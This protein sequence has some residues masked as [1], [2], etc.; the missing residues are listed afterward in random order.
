MS[1]SLPG[2]TIDTKTP[3]ETQ[4]QKELE[5]KVNA[6]A[7][8]IAESGQTFKY[9]FKVWKKRHHGDAQ[10]GH[11]LLFSLGCQS[12][13]NSRGIHVA[14]TG[15]GGYGKSDGIKKMGKLVF[16]EFWKNGGFTP[17]TLYYS[18]RDMPDGVIVGLEDVVW[19]SDL[20]ATI[21]R[22]TTDFQEGALRVST[23]EMKGVEL[24]TA[25]RIAF[26]ASC[27][28]SQADEQIR[29]RFI[30][31]NVK[32]NSERSKEIIGHMQKLDEGEQKPE[33][34]E[35]ETLVCQALT[36]DLK[37]KLFNVKIPFAKRIKLDGDPRA[38]GMF[39]DMIRSS[40][41][42]RYQK[43][44]RD[45]AGRLIAT[46]EDFKNAKSLYVGIGGHDR[47]KYTDA[48]LKLLKAI[49]SNGGEATQA[50]LQRICER[51]AG[52]IS[53]VLNG[54]GKQG[55][56]LL[57]KCKELIVEDG[58]RPIKYRLLP[59]FNPTCKVSIEL[60]EPT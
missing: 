56:G 58:K 35:F 50:D 13:S 46:I 7:R 12:V 20:G 14:A 40:A 36:Y 19:N 52:Y 4:A 16:P 34:D 41:A 60:G 6:K 23:I 5:T 51:S 44:E 9:I 54:R 48:E 22:I 32:S 55:H 24:R 10:L 8:E 26:W 57:Y 45:E 27:V 37:Q 49:V 28:D 53:D 3:N 29:D 43:R 2:S 18:G 42:F 47:D 38:Y 21:K 31:Y 39:S 1:E 11:A 25:K 17:Q 59:G 33:D 30:M 15:E